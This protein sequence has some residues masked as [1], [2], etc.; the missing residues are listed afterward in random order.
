MLSC[1]LWFGLALACAWGGTAEG[2]RRDAADVTAAGAIGQGFVADAAVHVL[3]AAACDRLTAG[4]PSTP[5]ERHTDEPMKRLHV[6][7]RAMPVVDVFVTC[8][9]EIVPM[10]AVLP[11]PGDVVPAL[12]RSRG[13]RPAARTTRTAQQRRHLRVIGGRAPPADA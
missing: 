10:W 13:P 9:R 8:V 11:E 3:D 1:L 5:D 4:C 7:R 2:A 12:P 6:A